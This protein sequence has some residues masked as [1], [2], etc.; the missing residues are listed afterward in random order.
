MNRVS[1]LNTMIFQMDSMMISAQ[2]A[3]EISLELEL[4]DVC[5]NS[6]AIHRTA[7]LICSLVEVPVTAI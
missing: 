3:S 7:C 5:M 2:N 6:V 1:S 4:L